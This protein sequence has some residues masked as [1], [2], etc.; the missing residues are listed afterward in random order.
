MCLPLLLVI[1]VTFKA[2]SVPSL[3]NGSNVSATAGTDILEL[4]IGQSEIVPEFLG[5]P[6]NDT[7]SAAISILETRRNH[8]GPNQ[9]SKEGVG[10]QPCS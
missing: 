1:V 10:P 6:A 2:V 4:Y 8:K 9:G 3:C 7:L 5:H